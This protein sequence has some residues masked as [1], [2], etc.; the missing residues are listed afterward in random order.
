MAFSNEATLK[1]A[2]VAACT[3]AVAEVEDKVYTEFAGNLNQYYGEF[4]PAEYIRTGE[5][6]DGKFNGMAKVEINYKN[7]LYTDSVYYACY[8]DDEWLFHCDYDENGNISYIEP[9]ND[10]YS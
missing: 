10:G 6:I 7:S 1:A 8:S 4:I 9:K 5:V 3:N 2:L